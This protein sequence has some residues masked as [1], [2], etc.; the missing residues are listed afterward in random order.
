M[1]CYY[2]S[3]ADY[4]RLPNFPWQIGTFSGKIPNLHLNWKLYGSTVRTTCP[5]PVPVFQAVSRL[6]LWKNSSEKELRPQSCWDSQ[7]LPLNCFN[8]RSEGKWFLILNRNCK[9][10]FL[11]LNRICKTGFLILNR[12]CKTPK[13]DSSVAGSLVAILL[14]ASD[15]WKLSARRKHCSSDLCPPLQDPTSV[16]P[17]PTSWT[18]L[19]ML[20]TPNFP[21]LLT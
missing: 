4:L 1:N 18:L 11:I 15:L 21:S 2:F 9:T 14:A 19:G 17:A 8:S 16:L 10:G 3:A 20:A 6:E 13:P 7:N 12:I 5:T